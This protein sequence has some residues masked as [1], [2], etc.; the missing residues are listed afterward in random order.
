MMLASLPSVKTVVCQGYDS[1][2]DAMMTSSEPIIL[3]GLIQNW[4]LVKQGLRSS[5]AAADYLRSFYNQKPV[6]AMLAEPQEQGRFFFNF[7]F[8]CLKFKRNKNF[9]MMS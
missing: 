7:L 8:S 2:T 9:I 5:V 1:L 3:K 4:P 6:F